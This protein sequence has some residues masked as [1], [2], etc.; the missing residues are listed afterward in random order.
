LFIRGVATSLCTQRINA[1]SIYESL[2]D[3]L[4]SCDGESIFDDEHFT[5]STLY[6]WAVKTCDELGESIASNLRFM[7]RVV[8]TQVDKLC[9]EAHDHER[10]GVDYWAQQMAEELFA[11]ED[12]QAQILAM[13]VQVQESVRSPRSHKEH[14]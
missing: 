12:L 10:L 3:E 4:R 7:R 5:K 8:D 9:R 1:Q 14:L 11:L 13:S 2:R 6:H